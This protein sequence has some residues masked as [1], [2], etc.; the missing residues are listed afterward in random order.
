MSSKRTGNETPRSWKTREAR[1]LGKETESSKNYSS[2]Q[3]YE[4]I[5]VKVNTIHSE[6]SKPLVLEL[7]MDGRKVKIG[8]DTG[9]EISVMSKSEFE[10]CFGERK[11]IQL[12]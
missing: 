12:N 3:V 2:D 1:S 6:I 7:K 9:S 4:V 11:L 8:I 10:S 5:Y